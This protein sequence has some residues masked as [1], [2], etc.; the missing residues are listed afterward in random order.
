VTRLTDKAA[1]ALHI[2]LKEAQA[3]IGGNRVRS[4]A[5]T[6]QHR[7]FPIAAALAVL[8]VWAACAGLPGPA[9]ADRGHASFAG[10]VESL[11][12]DGLIGDWVVS[13]RTVHVSARTKII[14]RQ[15]GVAVGMRVEIEGTAEPDGSLTAMT[16]KV[17]EEEEPPAEIEFAGLVESLP[18]D[19]LIGDWVVRGVTV[20]VSDETEIDDTNGPPAVGSK[21]KVSGVVEADRSVTA[22]AIEVIGEGPEGPGHHI[23]SDLGV[24]HLVR[25]ETAPEEA[26]GVAVVKVFTYE[27]GSVAEDL[28]VGVEGLAAESVYDVVIDGI[29]A[30]AIATNDEGEGSLFLSSRDVPGAEPLPAELRPLLERQT[31]EVLDAEAAVILAGSFADAKWHHHDHPETESAYVAVLVNGE[32]TTIGAAVA[33]DKGAEQRVDVYAADL[34]PSTS[35]RLLIDSQLLAEVLTDPRGRL[36]AIFTTEP[37]GQEQVLPPEFVPVTALLLIELRTEDDTVLATGQFQ[38]VAKPGS[39]PGHSSPRRHLGH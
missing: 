38:Q 4:V 23:A 27:D 18:A 20:H 14:D 3:M 9:A 25:T 17:L 5:V 15:H 19:G 34:P 32:G 30:G 12:A 13:G 28:K 21:V 35:L 29:H 22:R 26:E 36:R 8:T 7:H 6:R 24:L 31:V 39:S 16:I 1:G 10:T 37:D 33:D 2:V 11:P